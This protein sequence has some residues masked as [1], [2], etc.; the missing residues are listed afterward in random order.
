[1]IPGSRVR[2]RSRPE[3]GSGHIDAVFPNGRCDVT[4]ATARFSGVSLS[5]FVSV[6]ADEVLAQLDD[7]LAAARFA[8]AHAYFR[9]K[10]T[11]YLTAGLFAQRLSLAH[12][13][14]RR[15]LVA[16]E[17]RLHDA[18][19]DALRSQIAMLLEAGKADAAEELYRTKCSEWWPEDEY[20]HW[21]DEL[22]CLEPVATLYAAG[23][24]SAIDGYHA[25]TLRTRL[26]GDE[27]SRLKLPK[28]RIRLARLG[29]PLDEEQM[30]ACARPERHRLIR[31]RAGSGKTRTLAALAALAMHDESLVPDQVLV[32]AFNR[33]AAREIGDRIQ[34]AAGVPEFRNSR[35]FHSLAYQLADHDGRE[36]IFDDG[37]LAPSRRKQ[38]G[39]VER[40]IESIM[41][42]S[43][44][45]LLYEFFRRELDQLDVLGS[46]LSGQD[47]FDFRRT[48]K[49]HT[50][51]GEEVKS[52]G[53][54]VIAD[55][56]FEH[57]IHYKY[58]KTAQWGR[59]GGREAGP[60]RPDFSILHAGRDYILEHWAIDPDD[61]FAQ[62]PVWWDTTTTEY[63]QQ[64]AAK[65][66]Y[67]TA[68]GVP[69]LESHA[70]MLAQGRSAFE[71]RLR[72]QF[73]EAG[74]ACVKLD[75]SEL[76]RR[77]AEAPRTVS[78]MA[79]LF[80]QFIS[81]AKK[82]GWSVADTASIIKDRPDVQPRARAFHEL[83]VRAY[84]A[85]EQRLDTQSA[86]DF[87][88]LL[89]AAADQ[90]RRHG[91]AAR[92]RLDRGAD[93]AVRDLRW[94]LID[95][96]QDFSA[97]YHRLI[98]A[99]LAANP[100]I[101]IV[102]VGD[103]W[104]AIN[105][106]AGAKASYFN[107]FAEYFPAA[108]A[109][110]ISTN[111][112]SAR[113]IVEAGNRLMRGHGEPAQA[114]RNDECGI[115]L[116][117][118]DELRMPDSGSIYAKAATTLRADGSAQVNRR[119]AR[120]LA[121]CANFIVDAIFEIGDGLA[122][123]YIPSVLIVARTNFAYG[124]D[125]VQFG[126]RLTTVLRAIPELTN[127]GNR[128]RLGTA[129][130]TAS[131]GLAPLIEV[132]T[133]HRS[134]GKEADTVIVLDAVLGQ[135]PKLHADNYL[136]TL[137]GTTVND[138]LAE[139]RRLFYVAVTRTQHRLMI[140]SENGIESPYVEEVVKRASQ[141]GTP[142]IT[143]SVALGQ[144]AEWLRTRLDKIDAAELV[145]NNVSVG[146]ASAWRRLRHRLPELPTVGL[147]LRGDLHAELA[148]PN[149]NPP[150]A[151]LTGHHRSKARQWVDR[152][153]HVIVG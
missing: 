18:V 68:C 135:F 108:G 39:Y 58:E 7:M 134:K 87:D 123:T 70:A 21:C 114:A 72:A 55:F 81:R 71:D 52:A 43:F 121:A 62:V 144:P 99:V 133:A 83:A 51:Q 80:L 92:L 23:S 4:F 3:L 22:A 109:A 85:Y 102:G 82:Q 131:G 79:E 2:H 93:I 88:D 112:R 49:Q 5:T 95:E 60:Y 16:L 110:T 78:R 84:D 64:I 145:M 17:Q 141:A 153:W 96:F 101:R 41:N 150:I 44:R 27:L 152:G 61:P 1:M 142:L 89:V 120:A 28:L 119:L 15:Q 90:V 10:A 128:E 30:L 13:A 146:A 73:T 24:L 37:T 75:R 106:F 35:T 36:V 45:E 149:A 33:K 86:M 111:R 69:L 8:D 59:N 65:R 25:S 31:A 14:E 130:S 138:V 143:E 56:L 129:A 91:G 132:V 116:T 34:R 125:L 9:S 100:A 107:R 127:V 117:H 126:E 48:L 40:T 42:P 77:V 118:I 103:D 11:P 50:L 6:D 98:A 29:M 19:R 38:S 66:E 104:Q 147:S 113:D 26:S 54:T 12:Q 139:E 105:A 94:I 47:Y 67:W 46:G 63:R 136:F 74:I 32:L 53:E 76:M 20:Q 148:W 137:F 140:L 97:L 115:V 122:R 57:G 124:V 151:I